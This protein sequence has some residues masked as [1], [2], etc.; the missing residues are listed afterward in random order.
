[1]EDKLKAALDSAQNSASGRLRAA[2]ILSSVQDAVQRH[3]GNANQSD[4]ITMLG[5]VY[6]GEDRGDNG[7][8]NN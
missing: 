2:N 1:M 3:V 7:C 6:Y 4:D 5:F 8:Q